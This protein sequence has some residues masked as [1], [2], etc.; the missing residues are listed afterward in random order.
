MKLHRYTETQNMYLAIWCKLN[1][2]QTLLKLALRIDGFM[3]FKVVLNFIQ[4]QTAAAFLNSRQ[5][6]KI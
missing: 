3:A 4:T 5:P 2:V 6:I 1:S